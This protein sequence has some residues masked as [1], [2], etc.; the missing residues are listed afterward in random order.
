MV[1]VLLHPSARRCGKIETLT[2][3][4]FF[5]CFVAPL[6]YT[7]LFFTPF[8][9]QSFHSSRFVVSVLP[10]VSCFF[11]SFIFCFRYFLPTACVL[12]LSVS[13][14]FVQRQTASASPFSLPL[15]IYFC[16]EHQQTEI[17]SI[18]P[19]P[20][21]PGGSGVHFIPR[22]LHLAGAHRLIVCEG[23]FHVLIVF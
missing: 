8:F 6:F 9:L 12:C 18:F 11:L 17:S 7:S 13:S 10:S 15:L 22:A 19:R 3:D 21:H 4:C 16:F 23:S 1:I 5:Y 20:L 2:S 14:C